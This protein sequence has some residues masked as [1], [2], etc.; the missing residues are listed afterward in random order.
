MNKTMNTT[1]LTRHDERAILTI[2]ERARKARETLKVCSWCQTTAM[3]ELLRGEAVSHGI[4]PDCF[5]TQMRKVG[6]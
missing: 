1:I 6:A 3:A 4:C 2:R 5:A